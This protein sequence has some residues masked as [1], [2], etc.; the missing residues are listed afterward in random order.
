MWLFWTPRIQRED[1]RGRKKLLNKKK[2][3]DSGLSTFQ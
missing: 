2:E 1:S 3:E